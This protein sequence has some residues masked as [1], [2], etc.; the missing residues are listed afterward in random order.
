MLQVSWWIFITEV[1]T[2]HFGPPSVVVSMTTSV[3]KFFTFLG[4]RVVG[5]ARERSFAIT[6]GHRLFA[7][8]PGVPVPHS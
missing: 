5:V 2:G 6:G 3:C 7:D 4:L 1:V 8:L